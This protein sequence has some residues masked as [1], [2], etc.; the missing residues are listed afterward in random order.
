MQTT[1]PIVAKQN[2]KQLK[3]K[4][5]WR[6][7]TGM[8]MTLDFICFR[9]MFGH[10]G[11]RSLC[12]WFSP[13]NLPPSYT[14]H[15]RGDRIG[16]QPHTPGRDRRTQDDSLSFQ[17]LL[18]KTQNRNSRAWQPKPILPSHFLDHWRS[19]FRTFFKRDD[20]FCPF[21]ST[22][23]K[24]D[25]EKRNFEFSDDP[26]T[27]LP[28][29]G[30]AYQAAEKYEDFTDLLNVLSG[31]LPNSYLTARITKDT[32][33]WKEV[34]DL[35]YQHYECKVSRDTFLDFE[36]LRK[37]SDENHIQYYE[38]LLQHA[39]LHLAPAGAEVRTFKNKKEDTLTISMMNMIALNWLRKI[40]P[41]LI[42]IVRAE[43]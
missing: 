2:L 1:K 42:N 29:D 16:D 8:A 18:K 17:S 28:E 3:F 14:T 37:E 4:V 32:T 38:R 9:I 25:P 33:C 36:S 7:S 26:L 30:S 21:L 39:T 13:L 12:L 41:N 43:Y 27:D 5:F 35:I 34:W 31:S 6:I 20:T 23:F 15:L 19:Q 10:D 24:W 22:S 40:D 11:L